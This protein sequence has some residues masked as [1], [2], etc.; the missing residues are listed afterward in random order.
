MFNTSP[1]GIADLISSG[2]S[3]TVEFKL[4]LSPDKLL[5]ELL[6]AFA[7]TDGGILIVGVSDKG[8]VVGMSEA[9]ATSVINRLE[10]VGAS[11]LPYP[12]TAGRVVID[13]HLLV[14]A[15]VDKAPGAL[16]PILTSRGLAMLRSADLVR[17][18]GKVHPLDSDLID[19]TLMPEVTAF[20]AMSFREEEEPA[21]VDYF[22]AMRRAA[23]KAEPPIKLT[24]VDLVE[25]DYEISQRI[26]DE[27]DA[28]Q[29]VLADFTLNPHNVYFEL[30]Y[31]RAKSRRVI[32]TA[33]KGT[34]LQFDVRNWR[35][36]FYR[37]ATELEKLL[38]P[39]LEVAYVDVTKKDS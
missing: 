7:N 38:I 4:R 14:Y 34:V 33:R 8:E 18:F 10:T 26:M 30:G 31:A 29:I 27:I 39:E 19:H 21:L 32:Q 12:V 25:G 15:I 2:E 23:D 3:Q 20:V 13:G 37:N 6:T 5:G 24:R 35:T 11:L 17:P 22:A 16:R 28:A 1:K 9:E 36:L